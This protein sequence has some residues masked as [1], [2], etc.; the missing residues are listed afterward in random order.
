MNYKIPNYSAKCTQKIII[1]ELI[2]EKIMSIQAKSINELRKIIYIDKINQKTKKKF[3]LVE[4][5]YNVYVI[6]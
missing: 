3:S 5:F 4:D 2:I 1:Y 6:H